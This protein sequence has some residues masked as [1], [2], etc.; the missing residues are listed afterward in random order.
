MPPKIK[1]LNFL[2]SFGISVFFASGSRMQAFFR[3]NSEA[4]S[5]ES[6]PY[7]SSFFLSLSL[8]TFASQR[9]LFP[10]ISEICLYSIKHH[11]ESL[12]SRCS[13]IKIGIS[14]KY[15]NHIKILLQGLATSFRAY[16]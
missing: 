6:L 1:Y 16:S 7:P 13:I 2:A 14:L 12:G 15:I 9:F 5:F 3:L 4:D 10:A 8:F 11:F